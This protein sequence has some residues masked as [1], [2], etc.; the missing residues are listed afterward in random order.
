[1]RYFN[2]LFILVLTVVFVSCTT[3]KS[4]LRY[5]R[6][7]ALQ[8]S[9]LRVDRVGKQPQREK[10]ER[11][12]AIYPANLTKIKIRVSSYEH[13]ISHRKKDGIS[14]DSCDYIL[15]KTGQEIKGKIVKSDSTGITYTRCR[16]SDGATYSL[17][18]WEVE[19]IQYADGTKEVFS[20]DRSEPAPVKPGKREVEAFGIA[21]SFFGLLGFL[22]PAEPGILIIPLFCGIV[23]V[24]CGLVGI[25]RP[26]EKYKL[27]G[28]ALLSFLIGALLLFA[29]LILTQAGFLAL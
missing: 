16:K 14:K 23:A 13:H 1:M 12:S 8:T 29:L 26:K 2:L 9:D 20:N 27:R 5:N 15:L 18:R 21:G 25:T 11:I 7:Q 10:I 24:I 3:N 22:V 19:M 28:F 6:L 4:A 17:S